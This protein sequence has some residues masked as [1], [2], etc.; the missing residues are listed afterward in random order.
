MK[1]KNEIQ[2]KYR[3]ETLPNCIGLIME[4]LTSHTEAFRDMA[5]AG[6]FDDQP[7]LNGE[8]E[9]MVDVS[10]H[11]ALEAEEK[12]LIIARFIEKSIAEINVKIK[13]TKSALLVIPIGAEKS[14]PAA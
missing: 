1:I 7:N 11:L 4:P 8:L 14:Q 3:T 9:K 13:D 2:E 12:L 10:F 6:H 5:L